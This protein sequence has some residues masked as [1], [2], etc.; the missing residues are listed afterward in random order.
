MSKNLLYKPNLTYEKNYYTEGDLYDDPENTVEN[1]DSSSNNVINKIDK[2][3]DL[4]NNIASK[5]PLLPNSIQQIVKPSIDKI[6]EVVDDIIN[7]KDEYNDSDDEPTIDVIPVYPSDNDNKE[8]DLDDIPNDPFKS[9]S[10]N[11]IS[12]PSIDIDIDKVIEQQYTNDL[13]DI[14]EDY[15]NKQNTAMQNYINSLFTYAAYSENTNIKNY[16]S[17]TVSNKNLTHVTDYITKSKIGLKQQ[18]RLYNKLFTL[19]ETI[20]HLRAVKVAKEQL[21]RYKSNERIEDKNLL[22]KSANDLLVESRLVAEKKYEENFYGLYKY[23]NSSVIIFNE[24]MNTYVKQKRS[25][26][27]LNNEERE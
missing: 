13:V 6:I 4:K 22:T 19:D 26:I 20:Y 16:T 14:I 9:E 2:L 10:N 25:L 23:L 3:E 15:L 1:E 21:K 8:N 12:I 5:L 11:T 27:L 24:C 7:N 18:I 17:K